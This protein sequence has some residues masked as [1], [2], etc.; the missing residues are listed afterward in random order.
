MAERMDHVSWKVPGR[1]QQKF[2][3]PRRRGVCK[4]KG[5]DEKLTADI[6]GVHADSSIQDRLLQHRGNSQKVNNLVGSQRAMMQKQGC[7]PGGMAFHA[8][9]DA[10]KVLN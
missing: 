10:S 9:L 6:D 3:D 5:S 2:E 4:A 8:L 1:T 7:C